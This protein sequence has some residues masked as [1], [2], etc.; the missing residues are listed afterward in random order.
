MQI[1][2]QA[3]YAV[4]AILYLARA[5]TNAPPQFRSQRI[6]NKTEKY[7]FAQLIA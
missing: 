7:T 2:R 5:E 1:T 3:D 4:G 6:G